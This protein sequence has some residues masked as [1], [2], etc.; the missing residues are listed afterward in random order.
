[1]AEPGR[2]RR[3]FGPVVLLGLA[4]AGLAAVASAKPWVEV[5]AVD[6][7]RT[8][9]TPLPVGSLDTGSHFPLASAL[10]L[11]LLAGWGVLLVTR[12]PVRRVFAGLVLVA[13]SAL[14]VSVVTALVTLPDSARHSFTQLMG[15]GSPDTAFTGWFLTAA[16]CALVGLVPAALAVRLVGQWPEMGSRYDAPVTP[17]PAARPTHADPERELWQSLDDGLDPTDTSGPRT[18]A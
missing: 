17:D 10:S 11:V 3:S 1:M 5:T 13:A 14:A 16:V 6:A 15:D 18:D 8:G 2:G 7:G 9:F 12:G 4:S